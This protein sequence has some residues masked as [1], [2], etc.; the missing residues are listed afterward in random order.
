[1]KKSIKKLFLLFLVSIL[2]ALTFNRATV[3]ARRDSES[4]FV[5]EHSLVA[6][7]QFA[8]QSIIW[9][10][11]RL[12]CPAIAS[13][14][15][16]NQPLSEG[17]LRGSEWRLCS[18]GTLEIEAGFVEVRGF[19]PP[20]TA[21]NNWITQIDILGNVTA[22][23]H[24]NRLFGSLVNLEVINGLT[25]LDTSAT[26]SMAWMFSGSSRLTEL[27]VSN[28]NTANVW[29]MSAMFASTAMLESLDVS[30]FDTSNVA[31][32]GA[33]F[34]GSS[35]RNLDLSNFNTANVEYMN[36][37]FMAMPSLEHLDVSN[38]DTTNVR[39]MMFMF[40]DNQIETLDLVI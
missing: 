28:F 18:N 21:F 19:A 11:T 26:V 16:P 33:M 24:L 22:G 31:G 39:S 10:P 23:T 6:P 3:L 40:L 13:G 5:N 30:N 7:E 1:M 9:Q 27:D 25:Y 38:F 2:T 17:W 35:L 29:D 4:I 32:M 14:Q 15:F 37:M 20:W 8:N 36:N 12:L 34:H